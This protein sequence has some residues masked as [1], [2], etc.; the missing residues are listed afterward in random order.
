MQPLSLWREALAFLAGLWPQLV[1]MAKAVGLFF[2]GEAWQALNQQLK[3][4]KGRA[5]ALQL[6]ADVEAKN[7]NLSDGD[8]LKQLRLDTERRKRTRGSSR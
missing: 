6:R 4:Q 7:T 8:V 1:A 5:N 3:D 2:T